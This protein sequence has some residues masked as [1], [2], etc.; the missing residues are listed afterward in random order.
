MRSPSG[1]H[2][3][4]GSSD[5]FVDVVPDPPLLAEVWELDPG[6]AAAISLGWSHREEAT[7]IIDD[8][9]GRKVCNALGLPKTGTAGVLLAAANSGFVDFDD[10]IARLQATRFRLHPEV[11][12]TL[13]H[14]LK[15]R[16]T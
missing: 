9:D 3:L 2:E 16:Q 1:L 13:R 4:L 15:K 5:S 10:A 8:R 14:K 12:I 7:L 6:E 11:V